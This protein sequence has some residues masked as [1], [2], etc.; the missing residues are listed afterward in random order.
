MLIT[1]RLW[2]L[3]RA[4]FIRGIVPL[5][6]KT[7]PD[8]CAFKIT[9]RLPN[10]TLAVSAAYLCIFCSL[11]SQTWARHSSL[12]FSDWLADWLI[13]RLSVSLLC[14]SQRPWASSW[15]A[16]VPRPDTASSKNCPA[17]ASTA[18]TRTCATA[19]P[20]GTRAHSTTWARCWASGCW[21]CGCEVLTW[22]GAQTLV[23]L[24]RRMI[25]FFVSSCWRA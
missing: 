25:F 4:L 16:V 14:P 24:R 2:G 8:E 7:H 21:G 20:P 15:P 6:V 22:R 11:L 1:W 13:D 10:Y 17:C 5:A 3:R 23:D 19:P 18:A 9:K 12:L